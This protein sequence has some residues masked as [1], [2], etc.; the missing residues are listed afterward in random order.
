MEFMA[1][2]T[3]KFV[4]HGIMWY[5]HKDHHQV[6][7]GFFEKND[8]FFLIYAIPSWLCIMLGLMNQIYFPVWIGF[9]IAAYGLAQHEATCTE[10]GFKKRTQSYGEC[11][12]ELHGRESNPK[13]QVQT[14]LTGDGTV[15]HQTCNRF[16]FV[17][18]TS[19][20]SECRLKIDIAKREQAQK[21]VAYEAEQRRYQEELRRYEAQVAELEKERERRKGEAMLRFGLALMGGT[22]PN[23][24]ENF[25]N[26][27]R[28]SLGLPPVAPSRPTFQ[29]FTITG[30]D[31]RTTNCN[32]FGNNITCN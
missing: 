1:W 31:R 19:S 6:E 29:N 25:A 13:K 27:G 10:L 30:P 4:M 16:G 18:G 20:Y 23:A 32:V 21:Q 3:H 12:L 17:I 11:V 14:E 28:Q 15:E 5:F 7:P 9:G 26:A 8:V 22:S 24:S 2:A